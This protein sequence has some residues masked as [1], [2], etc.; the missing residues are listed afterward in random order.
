MHHCD[1]S[2]TP[3]AATQINTMPNSSGDVEANTNFSGGLDLKYGINEAFTLDMILIP[4]F[5]Q[6]RSDIQ[7][8]NLSPF[9][10]F[11]NEKQAIFYG[12]C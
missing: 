12:R 3:Y 4:D 2:V 9:E 6:V 8:L 11:F 7:V 1:L 10:V 5:S